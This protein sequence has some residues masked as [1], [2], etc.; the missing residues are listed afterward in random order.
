M[1]ERTIKQWLNLIMTAKNKNQEKKVDLV[2]DQETEI[3]VLNIGIQEITVITRVI[4]GSSLSR[5]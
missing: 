4:L 5:S 1:L 3:E 2:L